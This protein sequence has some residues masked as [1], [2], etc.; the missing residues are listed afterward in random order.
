MLVVMEEGCFGAAM[1]RFV[2]AALL[3]VLSLSVLAAADRAEA[4]VRVQ[5][6]RA[7]QTME[8]SLDGAHL[9]TWKVSTARPGYR[10]PTGVFHPQMLAARWFSHVYYNSPMPHAIFFH[11]GFAIHGSYEIARLG[12]PASHGCVRLHPTDAAILF[13]LVQQEGMR[14]TTIVVQ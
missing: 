1:R 9:Y 8:V 6:D 5:I 13:G 4:G 10:T 3:A 14:N 11:G 2:H 12:G 7:T